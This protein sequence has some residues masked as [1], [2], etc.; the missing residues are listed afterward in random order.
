MICQENPTQQSSPDLAEKQNQKDARRLLGRMGD[1]VAV[2]KMTQVEL[3]YLA[4]IIDGEGCIYIEPNRTGKAFRLRLVIVSTDKVLIDWIVLKTG[5]G[6]VQEKPEKLNRRKVFQFRISSVQAA[7]VLVLV[8]PFLVIKQIQSEIA[9]AFNDGKNKLKRNAPPESQ[10][11]DNRIF[12]A[13]CHRE[14]KW[15]HQ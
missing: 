4:G 1:S 3:S 6:T 8:K 14:L 15:L 12:Q 5:L 7:S 9:I 11:E 2:L 10:M 13:I